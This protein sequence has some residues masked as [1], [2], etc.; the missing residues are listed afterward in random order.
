MVVVIADAL[1]VIADL[2]RNL[3]KFKKRLYTF[4]LISNTK[5]M[6]ENFALIFTALSIGYI[7]RRFQTLPQDAPLI[8]NQF[9]LYISLPAMAL[10]QIPR[11][12]FSLETLLPILVAWAVMGLSAL[13]ILFLSRYFGF[14]KKLTGALLLV[15]VLGNTSFLGIPLI[16]AYL[17]QEAL[18]YVLMYDQLGTFIALST[19]GTIVAVYYSGKSKLDLRSVGKKI[20]TFP[21]FLT[22][23]LALCF[24][25]SEFP[26]LFLSVLESFAATIVPLAL[27]S[28]GLQLQFTLPREDIKPFVLA[29]GT[30]LVFAPLV[31]FVLFFAFGT[32]HLS[33]DVAIMEA[34]MGPM[35]TAGVLASL[36]GLAPRLSASVVGYG[37]LLS[38]VTTSIVYKFLT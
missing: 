6:M 13:L 29:L 16:E 14:D 1:F 28:V 10:L 9:I 36:W 33:W 11:L 7:L 2:I 26:P 31:A 4:K 35:I 18:G 30:T 25:G 34:S 38:F 27:V 22:L 17:G 24:I 21:P 23:L 3:S 32:K 5:K 37:T 12:S 15:G 19:Y 20:I 8:F